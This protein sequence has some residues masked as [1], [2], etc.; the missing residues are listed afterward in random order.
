M[1]Y[2]PGVFSVKNLRARQLR[3][4]RL[5]A[6]VLGVLDGARCGVRAGGGSPENSV[7]QGAPVRV[8]SVVIYAGRRARRGGRK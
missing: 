3:R 8:L 6:A 1:S 4:A 5:L 2:A 7:V